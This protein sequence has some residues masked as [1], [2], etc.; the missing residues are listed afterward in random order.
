MSANE[1]I[2]GVPLSINT[3]QDGKSGSGGIAGY[4]RPEVSLS[5]N[6]DALVFKFMGSSSDMPDM[7]PQIVKIPAGPAGPQG[8]TGPAGADGKT[9]VSG[10]DYFTETDKK[11]MINAVIAALPVYNGEVV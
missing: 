1:P 5:A 8:E 6:G 4:Y 7:P 11:E 9:P 2:Y 10:V 3:R